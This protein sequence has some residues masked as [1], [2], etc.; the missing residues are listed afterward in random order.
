MMSTRNKLLVFFPT[1]I[2]DNMGNNVYYLVSYYKKDFNQLT[3][4]HKI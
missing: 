2:Q 1:Q 4:I 3:K